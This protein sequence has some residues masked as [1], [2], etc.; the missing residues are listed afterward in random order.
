VQ[1]RNITVSGKVLMIET[2]RKRKGN[3]YK[4]KVNFSPDIIVLYKEVRNLKNLGFHVPL[5]IVN[6]AHQ[7][8]QLYPYAIS[9]IDSIKTYERT[10]EKIGSNNSL[11]I[12]V[13]G[14]RKEIQ[15]LLSQGMDLMWDTYKLEPYVHRFS[16]YVYTF[17]EKVDELLATEEQL[18]VDV[19][20]LDICQYAHT[21]FA[22]ILNKIQKAVDD[23][24]LQQYSNLH[25]RV[26]SLDDL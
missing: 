18:D 3:M 7:A 25:I 21:T 8:N 10:I 11:L 12:L 16:E 23:L 26:Q 4:L 9:L 24:S 6:K 15:N 1:Q 17:Q 22:D 14:M 13:A 5:S 20:S 19:N 2:V